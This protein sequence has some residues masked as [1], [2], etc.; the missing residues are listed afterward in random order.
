VERFRAAAVFGSHGRP[1]SGGGGSVLVPHVPPDQDSYDV[2]NRFPE[3]PI[4]AWLLGL[5]GGFTTLLTL[6]T[7]L[8]DRPASFR[9]TS[10]WQNHSILS[11]SAVSSFPTPFLGAV[12][13]S[14]LSGLIDWC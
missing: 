12:G 11:P 6:L 3:S 4:V 2:D 8:P 10:S 7:T 5:L 9:S 13:P 14:V 1:H